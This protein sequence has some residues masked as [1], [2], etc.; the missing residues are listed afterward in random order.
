MSSDSICWMSLLHVSKIDGIKNNVLWDSHFRITH[1]LPTIWRRSLVRR[2][3]DTALAGWEGICFPLLGLVM[4]YP[5][6]ES[7]KFFINTCQG[8][9]WQ[10]GAHCLYTMSITHIQSTSQLDKILSSSKEKLSVCDSRCLPWMLE[11]TGFDRSLTS[12]LHGLIFRT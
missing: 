2:S 8:S 7:G 11:S 3:R 12:M 9:T 1:S 10:P 4:S 6:C 5:G